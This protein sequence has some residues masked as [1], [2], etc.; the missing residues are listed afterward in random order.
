MAVNLS[1]A[2]KA[3]KS[4][5]LGVVSEQLNTSTNPFFN[6]I[7]MS[8]SNV[9]GKEVRK[10]AP[11]G[12][13]GGVG[14]GTED[15]EL[16]VSG[17]NN[18]VQFVSTLKNL[19]GRLEISDKAV[20]ASESS[21]GAFVN[22]LNDE[23]EGLL[24]ASKFNFSRMLHGDGSGKL[25]QAEF[26]APNKITVDTVKNIIEGMII[27]L[28]SDAETLVHS[29]ATITSIDRANNVVTLAGVTLQD[30]YSGFITVQG[31][32]NKEITGLSEIFKQ[33]GT[34]YGVDRSTN[35]WMVPYIETLV[36]AIADTKIQKAIDKIEENTG[37]KVDFII[38]SAGVKRAYQAYLESTKR[39]VNTMDL[40]GGYKAISYSG[41]P[42]VSD[43]FVP[44]GTMYLLD[45]KEFCL[46][47]L[48]DW[49]WLEDQNGNILQRVPGK[50]VYTATLVKYAE[51]MC[52]R[53]SSQG[54]LT[55]IT[56]A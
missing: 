1:T 46:H 55:G 25:A 24:K 49:R 53:P 38:C 8:T 2:D 9:W 50:P 14:A 29:A 30:T 15:G 44:P 28:Y 13:N 54:M 7:K 56:E 3:L 20:R 33:T 36:G 21:A 10:T 37:G 48:C 12:I 19:Y 6:K 17:S 43:R 27:D 42:I 23:M 26:S 40:A 11:F 51:L 41:I 22:L 16:P 35:S 45:S 4:Y 5:Y 52:N 34:L 39:N 47:Q 31:S 32:F 18:Y